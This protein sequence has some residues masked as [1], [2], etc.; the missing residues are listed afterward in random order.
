MDT[1]SSESE[2][3]SSESV[4]SSDSFIFIKRKKRTR[5]DPYDLLSAEECKEITPKKETKML[6]RQIE[7]EHEEKAKENK[8]KNQE[9]IK[10]APIEEKKNYRLK[11]GR[12]KEKFKTAVG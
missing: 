1:E 5:E 6:K 4:S 10:E 8:L 7:L 11:G 12:K 9:E 3:S 2:S